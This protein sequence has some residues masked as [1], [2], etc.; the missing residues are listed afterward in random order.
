MREKKTNHNIPSLVA[1]SFAVGSLLVAGTIPA[2]VADKLQNNGQNQ[3][4]PNSQNQM[5]NPQTQN[6]P[7]N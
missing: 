4:P 1:H 7:Q 2:I 3:P 6:Q 5:Q